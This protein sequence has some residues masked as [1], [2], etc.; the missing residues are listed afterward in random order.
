MNRT[1]YPDPP[2]NG[3]DTSMAAA[4]RIQ[5]A[6]TGQRRKVLDFVRDRG[7]LGA[8]DSEIQAGLNIP[9]DTER[10]RRRELEQAGLITDSGDRRDGCKVWLCVLMD[11]YERNSH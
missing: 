5:P 6:V 4:E 3:T 11:N 8:T 2:H 10:P 7:E 1:L 9:G